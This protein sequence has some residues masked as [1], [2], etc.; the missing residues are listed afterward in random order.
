MPVSIRWEDD[1]KTV[2]RYT[3]QGR[4]TWEE[5]Y[6]CF[7]EGI[8]MAKS[9]SHR[10]DVIIDFSQTSHLP[11]NAITHL[12]GIAERQVGNMGVGIFV[13]S[14]RVLLA[15]FQVAVK[16]YPKIAHYFRMVA[17]EAEAYALIEQARH[18]PADQ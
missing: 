10:F 6:P 2:M 12:R 15:I 14:S 17:T 1:D 16:V 8:E 18:N 5:L 3:I 7:E 11:G 4:W 13:T 9:V